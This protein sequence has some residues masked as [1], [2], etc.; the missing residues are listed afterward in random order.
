MTT[1][2]VAHGSPPIRDHRAKNDFGQA[3]GRRVPNFE[4]RPEVA[5]IIEDN[6]APCPMAC[7][8]DAGSR[9]SDCLFPLLSHSPLAGFLLA[10]AKGPRDELGERLQRS[11][12]PDAVGQRQSS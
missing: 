9:N 4:A 11:S 6:A 3:V 2:P 5:D 10:A 1:G 8:H 7:S 12:P